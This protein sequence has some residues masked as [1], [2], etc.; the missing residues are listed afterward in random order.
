MD[1]AQRLELVRIDGDH[2][3]IH[4]HRHP[5]SDARHVVAC[6]E[7]SEDGFDVVWLDPTVPLPVRYRTRED[8]VEDLVRWRAQHPASTRPVEIPS[9]PPS[10]F[11]RSR[12]RPGTRGVEPRRQDD[13]QAS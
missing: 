4:D 12:R 10:A 9:R 5:A 13:Q 8:I 11:R 6:V 1:S 7:E 2:W 3:L